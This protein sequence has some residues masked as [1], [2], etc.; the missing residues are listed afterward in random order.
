MN[1]KRPTNM[2]IHIQRAKDQVD[3]QKTGSSTSLLM[4]DNKMLT[5]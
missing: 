5:L 4:T 2:L 1:K 3:K